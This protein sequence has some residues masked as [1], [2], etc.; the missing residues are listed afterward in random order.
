L[1]S[2]ATRNKRSTTFAARLRIAKSG[3]VFP[4]FSC[5][6]GAVH[7]AGGDPHD[8]WVPLRLVPGDL[9]WS[10]SRPRRQRRRKRLKPSFSESAHPDGWGQSSTRRRRGG[11]RTENCANASTLLDFARS[12]RYGTP[13]ALIILVAYR[14]GLRAARWP[15]K[16]SRST[17]TAARSTP[18]GSRTVCRPRPRTARAMAPQA[19][20]LDVAP[21]RLGARRA[22]VI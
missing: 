1:R 18:I 15:T 20:N 12:Y 21:L 19:R 8:P 9:D 16:R 17:S 14:R 4:C 22:A 13:N 5:F 6:G 7:Y 3:F 10:N 11:R 2:S